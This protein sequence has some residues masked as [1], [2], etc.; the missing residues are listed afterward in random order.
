MGGIGMFLGAALQG[1]GEGLA[2]QSE[3]NYK[4]NLVE[5]QAKRDAALA[6]LNHQ[7]RTEEIQ[8][9][10]SVNDTL[11]SHKRA[12]DFAY[13]TAQAEQK[14]GYEQQN[15]VLKGKIDLQNDTQLE[16]LKHKYN[17]SEQAA[18]DA[19]QLDHDLKVAHITAD[20]WAVTTDGKLVAFNKNGQVISS[21]TNPGSFVPT[22]T[23]VSESGGDDTGTIAGAKAARGIGGATA[24]PQTKPTG[25]AESGWPDGWTGSQESQFEQL[26]TTATPQSAPRLFRNGQKIPPEEARRMIAGRL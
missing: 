15:I 21:S 26:Y 5:M 8:T 12:R 6:A 2:A 20:H 23:S 3:Q 25:Q 24:K 16:G 10:G 17:L 22:G 1:A 14:Q 9:T 19:R 18:D 13:D 4:T 11:D 7:Y